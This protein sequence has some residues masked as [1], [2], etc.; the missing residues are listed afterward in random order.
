M[1]NPTRVLSDTMACNHSSHGAAQTTGPV[2]ASRGKKNTGA[3]PAQEAA[4]PSFA[5]GPAGHLS[6]VATVSHPGGASLTV[7]ETETPCER[8]LCDRV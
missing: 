6:R 5:Q 2:L 1:A 3:F 7:R 8:G 4:I